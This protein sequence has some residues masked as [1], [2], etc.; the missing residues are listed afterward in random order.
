MEQSIPGVP[1]DFTTDW[2]NRVLGAELN[3]A[4]VTNVTAAYLPTPGQTADVAGIDL[5]FDG[6]TDFPSRLIAKFTAALKSTLELAE[7][8]DFYRRE[9]AFYTTFGQENLPIPKCYHAEFSADGYR[10]VLLLEDLSAG[11]SPSWAAQ[12]H[13]VETA[14]EE[15]TALHAQFWNDPKILRYDWLIE[16]GDTEFFYTMREN[17]I[18]ALPAAEAHGLPPVCRQVLEAWYDRMDE[19]LEWVKQRPYSVVHGDYHPKQMF[20]DSDGEGRFAI[21]DW[22][23]PMIG[24]AVWDIARVMLLGLSTEDRRINEQRLCDRYLSLIRQQGVSDYSREALQIDLVTGYLVSLGIHV[25]A[26][27][28]DTELFK[29]E[30]TDLGIDWFE[31]LFGRLEVILQDHDASGVIAQL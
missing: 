24:P 9:V 30:I 2:C 23:F 13:H 4:K 16:R 6:A 29:R 28:T 18:K 8:L 5:E 7:S 17:G 22:Q 20:F 15:V 3:G 27:D 31:P 25:L 14:V 1:A 10:F 21:I 26:C 12:L 11:E 19:F